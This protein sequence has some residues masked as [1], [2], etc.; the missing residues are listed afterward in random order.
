MKLLRILA[1]VV[2]G[3]W[4]LMIISVIV[5]TREI[6]GGI[7]LLFP[8]YVG[9]GVEFFLYNRRNAARLR[10]LRLKQEARNRLLQRFV[11]LISQTNVEANQIISELID[12]GTAGGLSG[13]ETRQAIAHG[14]QSMATANWD[15][16]LHNQRRAEVFKRVRD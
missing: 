12:M 8:L 1:W 7:I 4:S 5:L 14:W 2:I 11:E 13:Q 15:F 16:F 6:L 10:A 9:I 3:L